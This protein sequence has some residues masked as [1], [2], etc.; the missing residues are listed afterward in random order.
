MTAEEALAYLSRGCVDVVT[1]DALRA[2]LA[3]GRPL[4]VKNVDFSVFKKFR[5]KEKAELQV[6]GEL[7]NIANNVSFF[8]PTSTNNSNW[9]TGGL[10]TKAHDP[11][12]IQVA[13]KLVF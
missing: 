5:I 11:R 9:Q 10:I 8:Y 3:A 1:A 13:L 7:F 12:I 2:K 4:T 6:R